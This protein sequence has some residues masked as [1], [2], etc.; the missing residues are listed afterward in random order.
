MKAILVFVDGLICD[1]RQRQ[2]LIGTPDYL[3]REVILK[4]AP[5]PDSRRGLHELATRYELVY[6]AA[7][8][9]EARQATEDWLTAM[10]Y[11]QGPL[12]LGVT[13]A[14]RLALAPAL[15]AQFEFEGGL[16]THWDDNELHLELGCKSIIL[17]ENEVDWEIVRRHLLG[18]E[19]TD[20]HVAI[21]LLTPRSLK[22]TEPAVH[23]VDAYL[24]PGRL[25]PAVKSLH[26]ARWGYLSAITGLDDLKSNEIEVLYHFCHRAAVATLR[27]RIPR[28]KAT[29]PSICS[30]K[31]GATF[32]ERE[33]SEMFGIDVLG[34][35]NPDRLF[36][37]DEWP[38]D[39]PPL[40]KDFIVPEPVEN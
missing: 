40:L 14:D 34:T 37:P 28:D 9:E 25:L 36:L 5:T 17:K 24:D 22:I 33:L 19:H 29:I 10:N 35:P 27:V 8:P 26:D 2:H 16:G 11:P 20:L 31:A 21:D 23:R 6:L 13:P 39:K 30:I 4:D 32:F 38:T 7:R 12:F 1:T 18:Q 3:K 15:R